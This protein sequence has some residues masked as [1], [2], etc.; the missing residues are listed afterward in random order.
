MK[1][2]IINIK[3]KDDKCFM[4]SILRF[5]LPEEINNYPRRKNILKNMKTL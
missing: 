2:A 1:K 5:F 4:W 3:N